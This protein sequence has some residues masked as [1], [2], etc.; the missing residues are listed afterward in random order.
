MQPLLSYPYIRH[1]DAITSLF[2]F[3]AAVSHSAHG[4]VFNDRIQQDVGGTTLSLLHDVG[5]PISVKFG[6]S[7][8]LERSVWKLSTEGF[9][10]DQVIIT[11]LQD[12]SKTLV[13]EEGSKCRLDLDGSKQIYRLNRVDQINEIYAI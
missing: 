1:H 6:N 8:D 12:T 11:P 3:L 5:D 2:G 9:D 7:A 4:L 13:C 10:D